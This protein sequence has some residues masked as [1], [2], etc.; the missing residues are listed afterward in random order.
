MATPR[1]IDTQ[2]HWF[3]RT[4][5]DSYLDFDQYPRCRR[6]GDRYAFETAPG[7]WMPIGPEF[8]DLEHQLGI[9]ARAGV[10]LVVSSSASYGDVDR[11]APGRARELAIAVNEERSAAQRD[12]RS[13]FYGLATLPWQD[14]EASLC[15]LDDAIERLGLRG[16]LIHSN[17]AGAP[18]DSDTCRPVYARIAELGVPLFIHPAMTVAED[19]LRD[20]GLEYVVGFMFDS[21]LAGLR[22][23][24]SGIISELPGLEVVLPH[25]GG[26][27]PY[28]AGRIDAAHSRPFSLGRAMDPLPSEQLRRFH[29]DTLCRSTAG[30]RFARDFFAEGRMMF[31]S[32]NPFFALESEL[33]FVTSALDERERNAVLFDNAA[34]LLGIA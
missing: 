21:S 2:T 15:V 18:I 9:Y 31:G 20:W 12:H 16:V 5:L 22:L 33:E 10:D 28:L 11:H 13:R 30:L 14:T 8:Y 23:I 27:L 29:T 24:L 7:R 3:P 4:L 19:K 6:D 1:I 26:T 32:D 25:C 17:I 34:R